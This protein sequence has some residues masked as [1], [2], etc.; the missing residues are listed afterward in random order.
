LSYRLA[1][2]IYIC[3]LTKDKGKSSGSSI[4]TSVKIT[5]TSVCLLSIYDKSAKEN[6]T[7]KE[8]DELLKFIPK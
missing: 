5:A 6:L 4:I 2:S 3:H 7:D 8:L 1:A